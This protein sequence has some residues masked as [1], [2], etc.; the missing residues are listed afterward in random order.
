MKTT[1]SDWKHILFYF[2]LSLLVC[3][4]LDAVA[5]HEWR[6]IPGFNLFADHQAQLVFVIAHIPLFV[7]LFWLV[8]HRSPVVR[9]RTQFAVDGF[10][11]VHAMLHF[12]LSG[13]KNYD[14]EL[15]LELLLIYG[16]AVTGLMHLFVLRRSHAD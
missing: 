3:H 13:H 5:R 9:R 14:F 10:L 1:H 16:G 11:L 4:E 6:L 2:G 7:A 12:V 15:P 8:G